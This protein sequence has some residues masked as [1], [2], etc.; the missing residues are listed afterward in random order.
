MNRI[1]DLESLYRTIAEL[2]AKHPKLHG[3]IITSYTQFREKNLIWNRKKS[4]FY[5]GGEECWFFKKSL[6]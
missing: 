3:W 2:F 6:L 5:N 1:T 4:P